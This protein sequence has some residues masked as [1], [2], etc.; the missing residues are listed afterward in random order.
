[1]LPLNLGMRAAS[2]WD[3]LHDEPWQAALWWRRR[4][5][6]MVDV[7]LRVDTVCVSGDL[8]DRIDVTEHDVPISFDP[9]LRDYGSRLVVRSSMKMENL[10]SGQKGTYVHDPFALLGGA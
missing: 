2:I 3:A 6:P 8:P 5:G 1:V 7:E 9:V 10:D 4:Q